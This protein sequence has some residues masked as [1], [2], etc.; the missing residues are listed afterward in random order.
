MK[1]K[2]ANISLHRLRVVSQFAEYLKTVMTENPH[3]FSLG[4]AFKQSPNPKEFACLSNHVRLQIKC[5]F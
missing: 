1:R 3:I 2:K 4:H 5:R